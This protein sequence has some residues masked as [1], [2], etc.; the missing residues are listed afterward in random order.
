MIG[1]FQQLSNKYNLVFTWYILP[2]VIC[3]SPYLPLTV[4]EEIQPSSNLLAIIDGGI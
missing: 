3:E 1:S 2:I 4:T